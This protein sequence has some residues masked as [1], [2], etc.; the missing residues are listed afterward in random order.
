M[1]DHGGPGFPDISADRYRD[2]IGKTVLRHLADS[3]L[4][5]K[6]ARPVACGQAQDVGWRH[7][8]VGLGEGLHLGE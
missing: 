3:P 2:E 6:G 5:A 7:A 8:G 4:Q 1:L